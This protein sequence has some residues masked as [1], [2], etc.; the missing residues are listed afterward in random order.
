MP[1]IVLTPF[2]GSALPPELPPNVVNNEWSP[3]Y[4]VNNTNDDFTAN[5]GASSFL[6][7]V[8]SGYTAWGASI[9]WNT[10]IKGSDIVLTSGDLVASSSS[11]NNSSTGIS[12]TTRPSGKWYWETTLVFTDAT[13]WK[14]MPGVLRYGFAVF[15]ET[16]LGNQTSGSIG[17]T[18][19]GQTLRNNGFVGV[20]TPYSSGDTIR[21]KLD[22][23]VNQY[24]FAIE[25]GSFNIVSL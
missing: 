3:A 19:S 1:L 18:P 2:K 11:A 21:H 20:S 14:I 25:G 8:P 7:S 24:E 22:L 16:F 9:T 6:Y 17:T 4:S 12:T 15:L 10:T 13:D 23:D 5:F